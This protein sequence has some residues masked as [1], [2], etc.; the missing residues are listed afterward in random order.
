MINIFLYL[1]IQVI[2]LIFQIIP[3]LKLELF[4]YFEM[5]LGSLFIMLFFGV[6]A[7]FL[8]LNP[9]MMN[10]SFLFASFYSIWYYTR[11]LFNCRL[12]IPLAMVHIVYTHMLLFH[13]HLPYA[14]YYNSHCHLTMF[15]FVS[16]VGL[17][18]HHVQY[19][20]P[21]GSWN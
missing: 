18:L 15:F 19:I 20:T 1:G 17:H 4:Q 9:E 6:F 13:T 7:A 16:L 3:S 12:E 11:L 10:Y 2:L 21:I 5:L 14:L 8:T